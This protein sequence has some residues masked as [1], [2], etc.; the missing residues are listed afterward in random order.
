[1][2]HLSDIISDLGG[3]KEILKHGVLGATTIF[4]ASLFW[5]EH[6]KHMGTAKSFNRQIASLNER[7]GEEIRLM[8]EALQ[9]NS[10]NTLRLSQSIEKMRDVIIL[11]KLGEIR[12]EEDTGN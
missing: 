9:A 3:V 5:L 12:N 8:A 10:D 11:K 2:I 4:F 1:M 6:R 7:R